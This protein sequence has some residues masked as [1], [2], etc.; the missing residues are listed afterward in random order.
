LTG[1]SDPV[2]WDGV[3]QRANRGFTLIEVMLVVAI[4]GVLMAIAIGT[5]R[6]YTVRA[7]VSEGISLV[8][9]VKEAVSESLVSEGAFPTGNVAAGMVAASGITGNNVASVGTGLTDGGGDGLI[10]IVFTG[11][12]AI[13]LATLEFSAMTTAGS[14]VWRCGTS[15][16]LGTTVSPRFLPTSCR[17]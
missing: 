17:P 2:V 11:D 1:A 14:L 13:H 7:K 12:P 5:Y 9:A 8:A 3:M 6:D 16:G 15:V 4:L 10:S